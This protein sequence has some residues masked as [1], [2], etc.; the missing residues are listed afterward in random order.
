[1]LAKK[2]IASLA[3]YVHSNCRCDFTNERRLKTVTESEETEPV[4]VGLRSQTQPIDW[5]IFAKIAKSFGENRSLCTAVI[6]DVLQ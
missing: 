5:K 4:G 2:G 1:M 6:K 3:H